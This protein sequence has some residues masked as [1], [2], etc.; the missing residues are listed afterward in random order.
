MENDNKLKIKNVKTYTQD[1]ARAIGSDKGG[2]MK[3]II[4]EEEQSEAQKINLSPKSRKNRLFMFISMLLI[5][6][7][8][9][10]SVFLLFF[11]KNSGTVLIAPQFTSIIFT[12]QTSF[13]EV[14][15]FTKDELV[16]AVL[17]QVKSTKVKPGGIEGIYLAEDKKVIDF[18]RFVVLTKSDS[19]SGKTDFFNP[20]F[21]L[22]V[23]NNETKDFFILLRVRSFPDVFPVMRIWEDRILYDLYGF[24]ETDISPKTSYLFTKDWEDGI[25]GNK[26]ARIL[27]DEEGKIILMYVFINDSSIIITDSEIATREVILRLSSSQIKK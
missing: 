17:K 1:M 13:K 4:H 26:N 6:L 11:N 14:D 2:L 3:K 9:A 23:A 10:I 5:I 18:K 8:F 25:V 22:G 15:K 19:I 7:A 27:K 16:K 12:D 20:N 21:L 24:F